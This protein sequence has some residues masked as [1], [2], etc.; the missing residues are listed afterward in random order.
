MR[1]KDAQ[2]RVDDLKAEGMDGANY[3]IPVVIRTFQ[4]PRDV[5]AQLLR[6]DAIECDDE[7]LL[8]GDTEPFR[9]KDPLNPAHET[10][11]LARARA[12]FD[13]DDLFV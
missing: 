7:D 8:A 13:P 9:V 1:E 5:L 3:G 11:G 2:W 6:N 10:E 4:A 12:R